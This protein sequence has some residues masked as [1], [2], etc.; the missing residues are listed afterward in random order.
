M[1]TLPHQARVHRVATP[2]SPQAQSAA[3]LRMQKRVCMLQ[4]RIDHAVQE[5]HWT[6]VRSLRRAM[7]RLMYANA[8]TLTLA[9]ARAKQR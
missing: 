2:L 1:S 3:W 7:H 9:L 8:M 6:H 5:H 4:R